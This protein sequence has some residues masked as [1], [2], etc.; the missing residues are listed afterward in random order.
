MTYTGPQARGGVRA[1][2][3][4]S[5]SPGQTAERGGNS[6]LGIFPDGTSP[7]QGCPCSAITS[8]ALFALLVPRERTHSLLLTP[9]S[10]EFGAWLSWQWETLVTDAAAHLAFRTGWGSQA[11]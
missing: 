4:D 7:Q 1:R 3:P 2:L 10:G 5:D 11:T 9:L 6:S 8:L